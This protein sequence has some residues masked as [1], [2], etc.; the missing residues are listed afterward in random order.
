[1]RPAWSLLVRAGREAVRTRP[2]VPRL[3]ALRLHLG[4][5]LDLCA[6][7]SG[8]I[9]IVDRQHARVYCPVVP[10]RA[11]PTKR[12]TAALAA[13]LTPATDAALWRAYLRLLAIAE[14]RC[15]TAINHTEGDDENHTTATAS[16]ALA[17][18]R[19]GRLPR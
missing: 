11:T 6:L 13:R 5:G 18:H 19:P 10:P 12:M 7:P 15:Q 17:P 14:R 2:G 9:A 1:M 16:P 8:V 4:D 3:R